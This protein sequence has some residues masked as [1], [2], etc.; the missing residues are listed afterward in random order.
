[1]KQKNADLLLLMQA[2]VLGLCPLLAMILLKTKEYALYFKLELFLFVSKISITDRQWTIALL[3][4]ITAAAGIAVYY[5]S[6]KTKRGALLFLT[7]FAFLKSLLLIPVLVQAAFFEEPDFFEQ[8]RYQL[9]L[10]AY[11]VVWLTVSLITLIY[12]TRK[13]K[14]MLHAEAPRPPA[15]TASVLEDVLN[16]ADLEYEPL[17]AA[18]REK[19]FANYLA[20]M[21]II[22]LFA[23][24]VLAFYLGY[25]ENNIYSDASYKT[26]LLES[27]LG[28]LVYYTLFE[29]CFKSTP[30]KYLTGTRVIH[31]N[32]SRCTFIQALLRSLSRLIPFEHFSFFGTR[33]WHDS[34]TK[35]DVVDLPLAKQTE[36]IL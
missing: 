33:G 34:I 7:S 22:V 24:P 9:Y 28:L 25:E 8:Q 1:M 32:G 35:T 30:G 12:Y 4:S 20:D 5:Q 31:E 11:Y 27:F 26:A 10:L 16:H 2:A 14:K 13:E 15:E 21:F 23:G 19:R 36:S 17:V 18:P 3:I 6:G 29:A